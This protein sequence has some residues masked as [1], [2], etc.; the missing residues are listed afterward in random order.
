MLNAVLRGLAAVSRS[1]IRFWVWPAASPRGATAS[2]APGMILHWN[3]G[4]APSDGCNTRAE[5]L[6]AEAVDPPWSDPAAA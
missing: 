3:T 6:L 1:E 2:A 5:V 4:N